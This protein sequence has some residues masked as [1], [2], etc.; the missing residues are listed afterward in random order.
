MVYGT[1]FTV[2][3]LIDTCRLLN[4]PDKCDEK[5]AKM[6]TRK[7]KTISDDRPWR[8]RGL[9]NA[10]GMSLGGL[11]ISMDCRNCPKTTDVPQLF[12]TACSECT[13]STTYSMCECGCPTYVPGDI[14]ME[15]FICPSCDDLFH[16][17]C[18][19]G[20]NA[21]PLQPIQSGCNACNRS[22]FNEYGQLSDNN[23]Y[24][25]S[26][27]FRCCECLSHC[28]GCNGEFGSHLTP[29]E[30]CGACIENCH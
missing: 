7:K 22:G 30:D 27:C 18:K 20:K 12:T 19:Q 1:L 10:S 8:Q 6:E 3:T 16:Y 2:S 23:A 29:C 17:V 14:Y 13:I 25:C 28:S 11:K 9:E 26:D 5:G 4:L 15:V 24:T 21:L